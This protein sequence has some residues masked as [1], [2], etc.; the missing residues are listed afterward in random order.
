MSSGSFDWQNYLMT[1]SLPSVEEGVSHV[2]TTL[3]VAE[4]N[5]ATQLWQPNEPVAT[6]VILH[7]L[8]DH[9]GLYGHLIRYCLSRGW[10]VLAF[11]LPGHGL[12]DGKRAS[13]DSFQQYDQVFTEVMRDISTHFN[14]PVHV[15]GQSTGGAILINYLLKNKVTA[16]ASPFASAN[17]IAPLVRPREW[18]KIACWYNVLK[19]FISTIKRGRSINSH[20]SEFLDFL[21][22]HDPFQAGE[23]GISWLGALKEWDKFIRQQEPSSVPVNIVQGNQD[24]SVLWQYNLA[25]L[26]KK[27]PSQQLRIINEGRH[28]LVNE[29]IEYRQQMWDFFDETI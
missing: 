12:S 7:G 19:F 8:Y 14:E 15:F 5:I 16:E 28:H 1:Y 23:L 10:R 25:F 26:R 21:W 27:F 20:D 18:R 29:A 6:A 4:F 2:A 3:K 9:T 17:L 11:D 24:N 13:I 22:H